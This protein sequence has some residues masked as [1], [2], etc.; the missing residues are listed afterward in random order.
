MTALQSN[1]RAAAPPILVFTGD[2]APSAKAIAGAA[3]Q[4]SKP[5]DVDEF[6]SLVAEILQAHDQTPRGPD[7]DFAQGP[8]S[9]AQSARF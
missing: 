9:T 4:L 2:A 1:P 8:E 7:D 3:G 5:V 6:L